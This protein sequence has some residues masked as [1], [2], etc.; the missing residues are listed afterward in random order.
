MLYTRAH[1]HTLTSLLHTVV[2]R[3]KHHH[4]HLK[5]SGWRFPPETCLL[6]STN[7]LAEKC[8][9]HTCRACSTRESFTGLG[10]WEDGRM[11]PKASRLKSRLWYLIIELGL[12]WCLSVFLC[13]PS[14]NS[15]FICCCCCC[16]FSLVPSFSQSSSVVCLWWSL[17]LPFT[18]YFSQWAGRTVHIACGWQKSGRGENRSKRIHGGCSH[19]RKESE[20]KEKE[21]RIER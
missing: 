11:G 5:Y 14:V 17:Q 18:L 9:L 20:K 3:S 10:G 16:F 4:P 15:V 19:W 21:T 13:L 2:H 7:F 6:W 8:L 12:F 1:T